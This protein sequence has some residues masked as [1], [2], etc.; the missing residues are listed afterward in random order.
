MCISSM[1]PFP[2]L[3]WRDDLES[4]AYTLLFLLRGGLP[5]LKPDPRSTIFGKM[6]QIRMLKT[7]YTGQQLADGH[8]IEFGTF[9]D[10]IRALSF[11][12]VPPYSRFLDM[13]NDLYL[14]SGLD[15]QNESLDWNPVK[16]KHAFMTVFYTSD[17]L[18]SDQGTR[19]P[20]VESSRPLTDVVPGQIVTVDVLKDATVLGIMPGHELWKEFKSRSS[21]RR[22]PAVV[23]DVSTAED[24]QQHAMLAA[25]RRGISPLGKSVGIGT[26]EVAPPLPYDDVHCYIYPGA[27]S[28]LIAGNCIV[29]RDHSLT[30][31]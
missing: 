9:L 24:G 15:P 13:F 11:D 7:S 21:S 26:L 10:E 23:L 14:R 20:P 18:C 19:T 12:E 29:C 17:R 6:A 30:W 8:P 3:S 31:A 27:F 28:C 16:C 2:D 22:L 25:I 1:L 4:L 5:W